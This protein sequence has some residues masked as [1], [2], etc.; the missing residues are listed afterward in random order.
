[1]RPLRWRAPTGRPDMPRP[2]HRASSL[3]SVRKHPQASR[4]TPQHT[5]SPESRGPRNR[6]ETMS[7][8]PARRR[9]SIYRLRL[10][11]ALLLVGA[12]IVATGVVIG[13]HGRPHAFAAG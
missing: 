3:I 5:V 1:T 13:R 6:A 12:V 9:H 4:T 2:S 7:G 10:A 8:M 11:L